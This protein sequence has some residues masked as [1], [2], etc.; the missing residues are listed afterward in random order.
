MLQLWSLGFL[1]S[2]RFQINF[3]VDFPISANKQTKTVTGIF[4]GVAFKDLNFIWGVKVV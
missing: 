2:L 1:C 3:R 4:M